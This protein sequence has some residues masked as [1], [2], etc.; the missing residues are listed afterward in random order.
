[1]ILD[2]LDSTHRCWRTHGVECL[3]QR[4]L[5]PCCFETYDAGLCV[6]LRRHAA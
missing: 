6:R 4:N 1:M 2:C 5:L 3:V